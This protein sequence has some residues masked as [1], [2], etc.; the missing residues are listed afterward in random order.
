MVTDPLNLTTYRP[1]TVK[2]IATLLENFDRHGRMINNE[3]E[4][5]G[6]IPVTQKRFCKAQIL[7]KVY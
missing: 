6:S 3:L 5:M 2:N 7:T 1:K 4:G